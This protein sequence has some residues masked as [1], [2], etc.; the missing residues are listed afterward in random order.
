MTKL[1]SSVA[2]NIQA[3]SGTHLESSCSKLKAK[4]LILLSL[5]WEPA[6]NLLILYLPQHNKL[7]RNNIK[8]ELNSSKKL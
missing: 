3:I 1:I 6:I 7:L 5:S 4:V 8:F 2:G